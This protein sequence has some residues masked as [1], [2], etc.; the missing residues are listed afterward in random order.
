MP[1]DARYIAFD[2]DGRYVAVARRL[3]IEKIDLADLSVS[4]IV[5]QQDRLGSTEPISDIH[6]VAD[7]S[8]GRVLIHRTNSSNPQGLVW[9]SNNDAVFDSAHIASSTSDFYQVRGQDLL[10][11]GRF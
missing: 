2:A 4:T 7:P 5:S 10:T 9:D 3:S 6:I 8:N 1:Q 11:T